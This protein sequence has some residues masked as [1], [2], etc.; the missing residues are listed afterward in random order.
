[1]SAGTVWYGEAQVSR[2]HLYAIDRRNIFHDAGEARNS[3]A[4]HVSIWRHLGIKHHGWRDDWSWWSDRSAN[5]HL[6]K[7][8]ADI[9]RLPRLDGLAMAATF[10]RCWF[11]WLLLGETI[12]ALDAIAPHAA[13]AGEAADIMRTWTEPQR[14]FAFASSLASAWSCN[15]ASGDEDE[16]EDGRWHH[17][18]RFGKD[19]RVCVRCGKDDIGNAARL[20]AKR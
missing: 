8:W 13:T 11:P 4:F 3:H 5:N 7:L 9:G 16:D 15:G 1:M 12:A 6:E 10:D 18:V 20:V 17:H 19:E 2:V 14:G